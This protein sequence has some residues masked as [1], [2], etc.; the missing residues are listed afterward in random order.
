MPTLGESKVSQGGRAIRAAEM[1]GNAAR[2]KREGD[3]WAAGAGE[4]ASVEPVSNAAMITQ[5]SC[6]L[7]AEEV[8]QAIHS[9][10]A[11][12]VQAELKAEKDAIVASRQH[13]ADQQQQSNKQYDSAK[14]ALQ[15]RQQQQLTNQQQRLSAKLGKM[16]QKLAISERYVDRIYSRH[17]LRQ[18]C[19]SGGSRRCKQRFAVSENLFVLSRNWR[20]KLEIKLR[21]SRP[22]RHTSSMRP[23]SWRLEKA[24]DNRTSGREQKSKAQQTNSS[25]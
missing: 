7:D 14:Q 24:A 3:Q 12:S 15:L 5:L 11:A 9:S 23:R 6:L 19:V 25:K 17:A 4:C 16:H 20:S 13:A 22:P 10:S 2:W 21:L 8:R 18:W 1:K